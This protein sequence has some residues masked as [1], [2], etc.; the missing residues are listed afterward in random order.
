M[1]ELREKIIETSLQLFSER[2]FHGV[3]VN[4][5]VEHCKT[6]KGGFYHHFK[7]KDELLY[8]IH[9]TFI[10]YVLNEAN[11]AKKRYDRPIFQLHEMLKSLV[12][13]YDLYNEHIVV[14][15]QENK[16]LKQEYEVLI[17]RKRDDYKEILKEV[18]QEGQELN[19][20]RKELPTTITSM[21]VLGMVNWTYQWYKKDGPKTID[22]IAST[23]IDI[24]FKGLLTEEALEE[25]ERSKLSKELVF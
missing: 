25:Y 23:Y 15:N 21:S 12:R 10:S 7:S 3:T 8:V 24:I 20:I 9:D 22:Q 6:S 4:D 11:R 19:D 5:I 16:Y 17:K 13:V 14:F 2:G 1:S 18:I